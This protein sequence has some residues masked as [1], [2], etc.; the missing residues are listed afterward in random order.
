MATIEFK[1]YIKALIHTTD[2]PSLFPSLSFS[3]DYVNYEQWDY[4]V[5]LEEPYD[6][7]TERRYVLDL[8]S[9][10]WSNIA[11]EGARKEAAPYI[12]KYEKWKEDVIA[13]ISFAL[14]ANFPNRWDLIEHPLNRSTSAAMYKALIQCEG[15]VS[16]LNYYSCQILGDRMYYKAT[17]HFPEIL[18]TNSLGQEWTIRDYYVIIE[19][20]IRFKMKS[21][22]GYRATKTWNEFKLNYTHSHSKC[23]GND[24]VNFCFGETALDTLIGELKML[25]FDILKLEL[26]FQ[27]LPDYLSWESREGVPYKSIGAILTYEGGE[28]SA[29]SVQSSTISD[30]YELMIAN[31]VDL[32]IQIGFGDRYTVDIPRDLA[33]LR[34]MTPFVPNNFRFPLVEGKLI[35]SYVTRTSK[36]YILADVERINSASASRIIFKGKAV[37]YVITP[38]NNEEIE[39]EKGKEELFA[40]IRIF[41]AIRNTFAS[42]IQSYLND[43]YWYGSKEREVS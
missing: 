42:H 9:L 31:K 24:V 28:G 23:A 30:A 14:E 41:D 33:T 15:D 19:M 27:N 1:E 29:P 6:H 32:P 12:E 22:V 11:L 36:E 17:I 38:N 16:N 40:D 26:L 37:P 3:D 39:E 21:I 7:N 18:I 20:D 34:I 4:Y 25:P 10:V 2:A 13:Q 35:S 8:G 5:S 43:S